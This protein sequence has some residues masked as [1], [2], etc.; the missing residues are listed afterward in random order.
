MYDETN[1]PW[2]PYIDNAIRA[3]NLF[4]K[5]KDYI[6][7]D[8][9]IVIVDEFTG[10]IMADRRWGEGLHEACRSKRTSSN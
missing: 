2:I 10:R 8:N 5:E 1:D 3:K 4:L 9:E 6:V 7:R